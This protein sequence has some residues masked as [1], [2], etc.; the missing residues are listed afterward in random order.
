MLKNIF[1]INFLPLTLL[2]SFFQCELVLTFVEFLVS[3]MKK[4]LLLTEIALIF[5]QHDRKVT[6]VPRVRVRHHTDGSSLVV[7]MR[8][9]LFSALSRA[10]YGQARDFITV[11]TDRRGSEDQQDHRH[12]ARQQ[13]APRW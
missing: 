2:L 10:G 11:F 7:A 9:E 6:R 8:R 1:I 3:E 4:I 13:H 12:R 5:T